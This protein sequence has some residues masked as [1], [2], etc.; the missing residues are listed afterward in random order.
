MI[1][2]TRCKLQKVQDPKYLKI[3]GEYINYVKQY[4]YLGIIFDHDM[5]LQPLLKHINKITDQ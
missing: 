5:T 1:I 4:T 3:N 2:G